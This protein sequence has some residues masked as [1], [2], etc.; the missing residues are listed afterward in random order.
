MYNGST[1]NRVLCLAVV[2]VYGQYLLECIDYISKHGDLAAMVTVHV[3]ATDVII[4]KAPAADII[5]ARLFQH[6]LDGRIL[7][8]LVE[9]SRAVV[10][11]V[12]HVLDVQVMLTA[13]I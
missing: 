2:A 10:K 8:A 3:R 12:Q 13:V 6:A 5:T 7:S 9:Y 11:N 1:V 4:T